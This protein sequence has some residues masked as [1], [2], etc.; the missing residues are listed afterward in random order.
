MSAAGGAGELTSESLTVSEAIRPS[1]APILF[2]VL[3]CK[4]LKIQ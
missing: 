2:Y 1:E 3:V 4:R